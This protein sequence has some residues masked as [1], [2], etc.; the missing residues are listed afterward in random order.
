[1]WQN[2]QRNISSEPDLVFT[3]PTPFLVAWLPPAARF[4]HESIQRQRH[5]RSSLIVCPIL[6]TNADHILYRV[7]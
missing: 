1:L 6:V 5:S 4:C 3:G 7:L 2:E